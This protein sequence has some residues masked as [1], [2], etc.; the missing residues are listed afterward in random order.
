MHA[1]VHPA[2][3]LV[4]II[5][6]VSITSTTVSV[7]WTP[8]ASPNGIITQYDVIYSV[9]DD[10]NNRV[11]NTVTSDENNFIISHLGKL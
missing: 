6:V 3:G 11:A 1:C 9:Y 5:G 2:P 4:K 8:P 10:H 7:I